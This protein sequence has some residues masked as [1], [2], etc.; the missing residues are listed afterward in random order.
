MKT[1]SPNLDI[2]PVTASCNEKGHLVIGGCDTVDLVAQFGS[3]L[4]VI[5]EDTIRCAVS[6]CFAG[7][8]AYPNARVFYAGK[9]F[10]CLAIC[11][12]MDKLGVNL[13]VVSGG[14]LHTALKA[15]FSADRILMHG[16]NKSPDE[17]DAA[18]AASGLTI[19][20]DNVG[21]LQKVIAACQAHDRRTPIL[22]R[23]TPEVEA[24]THKHIKTGHK[25]SKFGFPLDQLDRALDLVL[26]STDAVEFKGLHAH[27][28]SQINQ[29][30]PYPEIVEIMA[31]L[32]KKISDERGISLPV[33]DVGGGL[34]IAYVEEDRPV[35]IDYWAETIASQ[36]KKS[37][38]ARKLPLPQ[39]FVEPGRSLLG[40]AGVTLYTAG[41]KKMLANGK[42]CVSVDG[43]MADNPRPITYQAKFTAAVASKLNQPAAQTAVSLVGKFCESGDVLINE[44]F[45]S[46]EPGDIIAVFATGAHNYSLSSNYNRTPRPACVLVKGGEANLIIKGE[47]LDD[48]ARNDVIP[49]RLK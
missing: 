41:Y 3:P 48:L 15:G 33:L 5:D 22:F 46:A 29:I 18:I 20:V 1:L 10:L 2:R 44:S 23:V 40:T 30:E 42:L 9:T 45:I 12:L 11:R 38:S 24:Q 35:A 36:I 6:S 25:D 8:S 32:Y 47:T 39:L 14:E 7:L 16:N 43:G 28:G 26:A 13:D 4:W 21:E 37:F 49:E 27:I 17:I 19:V 34:G 31:D